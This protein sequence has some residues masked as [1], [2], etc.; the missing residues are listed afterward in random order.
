M[1]FA[2]KSETP[3]DKTITKNNMRKLEKTV[4][5]ERQKQSSLVKSKARRSEYLVPISR[6]QPRAKNE[7][8]KPY[9]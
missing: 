5:M 6:I 7:E 4:T 3:T 9:E 2:N 1:L 8:T